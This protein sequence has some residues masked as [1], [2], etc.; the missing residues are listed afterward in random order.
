MNSQVSLVVAC[1]V[2]LS[3][4]AF[5]QQRILS[6]VQAK[7][8]PTVALETFVME[9]SRQ[10]KEVIVVSTSQVGTKGYYEGIAYL[11]GKHENVWTQGPLSPSTDARERHADACRRIDQANEAIR[12]LAEITGLSTRDSLY[13]LL[14]KGDK[15]IV[16]S[17]DALVRQLD[18][19]ILPTNEVGDRL[20]KTIAADHALAT[21]TTPPARIVKRSAGLLAVQAKS[22]S[23]KVLLAGLA[24]DDNTKRAFQMHN[25]GVASKAKRRI[26]SVPGNHLVILNSIGVAKRFRNELL[27]AGFALRRVAFMQAWALLIPPGNPIPPDFGPQK[28]PG[29]SV[30]PK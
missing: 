25:E 22:G 26:M 4:P 7:N 28:A 3:L 1:V 19:L 16:G 21:R 23:I 8:K 13:S 5:S 30:A 2:T 18:S 27:K 9:Y 24:Q 6:V 11:A 14:P 29:S 12:K 20:R 17:A 10:D 15:E